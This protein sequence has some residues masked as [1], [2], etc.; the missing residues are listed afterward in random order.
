MDHLNGFGVK[1]ED[2]TVDFDVK[3]EQED[4]AK[5]KGLSAEQVKQ[6][7]EQNAKAEKEKSTVGKLNDKLNAAN[8]AADA[9]DYDTAIAAL[10]D[11]TQMDATR[12]LIWFKLGDYQRL[13]AIKQTDP[14][15][16]Q[17][18]LDSA[19]E[20]YQKAVE[21][22]KAAP[23]TR[24]QRKTPRIWPRTTTTWRTLT[25][26]QE[27][28]RRGEDLRIVRADRTVGRGT[29]VLQYWR[30]PHQFRQAGRGQRCFR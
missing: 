26:G 6:M 7:Q 5:G 3:K 20:S 10:T 2:N 13:S 8:T 21:L 14:A 25:T 30:R 15:E 23:A 19:V 24:I 22:K 4:E 18:R 29:G 27:N 17:K 16:K 1:L 9:G 11:A 28:R 12:D